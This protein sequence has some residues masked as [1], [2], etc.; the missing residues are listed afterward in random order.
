MIGDLPQSVSVNGTEYAIRSDFRDILHIL[1]A[2]ND[3]DLDDGE[4]VYICLCIFYEDFDALTQDDYE[5]AFKAALSFIDLGA[6]E[7]EAK[8]QRRIM[9]WEQDEGLLFPAVNKVAGFETR[10]AEYVHWW[11]FMG[12]FMEIADG[13]FSYVMGL[14]LKKAKG[15][16]LEKHE[17]EYW[18]ANKGICVLRSK[19]SEEEKAEKER[20][21]AL[22]NG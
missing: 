19:L 3:P 6:E 8:P 18:D 2:F 10:T 9:D 16:K 1:E 4:K 13:A 7:S 11:T 17:R 15:K 14:R 5:A 21:E 22:L 20:L 12:Y